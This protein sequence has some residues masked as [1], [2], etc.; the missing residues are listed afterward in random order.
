MIDI[1][2]W[3]VCEGESNFLRV[4]YP[5]LS[6][7][8]M[9]HSHEQETTGEAQCHEESRMM[10]MP[11]ERE[12][13]AETENNRFMQSD[14]GETRYA[15]TGREAENSPGSFNQAVENMMKIGSGNDRGLNQAKQLCDISRSSLL[16][17]TSFS[18]P[19]HPTYPMQYETNCST[20]L[21]DDF[22][23]QLPGVRLNS[24]DMKAHD[25][26][27]M[28]AA[29]KDLRTF[30]ASMTPYDPAGYHSQ[31]GYGAAVSSAYNFHAAK[32]GLPTV[33]CRGAPQLT[34]LAQLPTARGDPSPIN[35]TLPIFMNF[36]GKNVNTSSHE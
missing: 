13:H 34:S 28:P 14:C 5:Q 19:L 21:E 16:P 12:N 2:D 18:T 20:G 36:R 3:L 29:T 24:M 27:M 30:Q 17:P 32:T 22:H 4:L 23:Y 35:A 1:D 25:P 8:E 10:T 15:E 26:R 33:N 7:E 31:L 9:G 6:S 11:E